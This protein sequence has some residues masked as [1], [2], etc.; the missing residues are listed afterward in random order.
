MSFTTTIFFTMISING[1]IRPSIGH[2]AG[3]SGILQHH[4][5]EILFTSI[6][7]SPLTFVI[8]YFVERVFGDTWRAIFSLPTEII[9]FSDT[10]RTAWKV[11][12]RGLADTPR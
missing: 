5:W 9:S 2:L 11:R 4:F 1:M 3:V 6:F 8:L 7:W 10:W 12:V